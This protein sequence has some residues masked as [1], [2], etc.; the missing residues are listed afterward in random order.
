MPKSSE[1]DL[2]TFYI[3]ESTD[4]ALAGEEL[5]ALLGVQIQLEKV[6]SQ[7]IQRSLGKYYR[8]SS[9]TENKIT[10]DSKV[11]F[12]DRLIKEANHLGSSDIPIEPQ[13]T[14]NRPQTSP[15]K[16]FTCPNQQCPLVV[17][18]TPRPARRRDTP[19]AG[20]KNEGR[21]RDA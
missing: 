3:D 1:S 12:V 6:E 2:L 19:R 18:R 11:D 9:D 21:T 8:N 17:T 7:L 5:E 20:T 16:R 14:R 15:T 10:F 4:V 13:K